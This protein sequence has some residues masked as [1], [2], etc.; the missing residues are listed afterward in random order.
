MRND[1]RLVMIIFRS[2]KPYFA[3]MRTIGIFFLFAMLLFA[4]IKLLLVSRENILY[5]KALTTIYEERAYMQEQRYNDRHGV[6]ES[7]RHEILYAISSIARPDNLERINGVLPACLIVRR[8]PGKYAVC[9]GWIILKDHVT[10]IRL[11]SGE[12]GLKGIDIEVPMVTQQTHIRESK[13]V[14]CHAYAC[15]IDNCDSNYDFLEYVNNECDYVYI[16]YYNG[17]ER[18]NRHPYK[19]LIAK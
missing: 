7:A 6:W 16:D 14:I 10:K 5:R 13:S 8:Y 11:S 3:S 1:S 17:N 2:L 18:I 4:T 9:I 15:I 12:D 19:Y